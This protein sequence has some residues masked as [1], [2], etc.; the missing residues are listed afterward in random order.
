MY[1]VE[2]VKAT[3]GGD[4]G[5]ADVGECDMQGVGEEDVLSYVGSDAQLSKSGR[6]KSSGSHGDGPP[7]AYS[8]PEKGLKLC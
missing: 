4:N 6:G 3:S 2:T 5:H 7:Q 1:N 8:F